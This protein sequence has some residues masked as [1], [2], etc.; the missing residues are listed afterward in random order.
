MAASDVTNVQID[1]ENNVI[2]KLEPL[3]DT[4]TPEDSESDSSPEPDSAITATEGGSA[5]QDPAPAPKRK[6]GRKPVCYLDS[7][8][9]TC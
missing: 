1:N 2:P 6:G 9:L 4:L 7:R 5:L 8:E 3:E